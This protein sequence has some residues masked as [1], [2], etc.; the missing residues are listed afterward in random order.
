MEVEKTLLKIQSEIVMRNFAANC[1]VVHYHYCG[2]HLA[3]DLVVSC[4]VVHYHHCGH[5]LWMHLQTCH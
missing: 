2:Y 5:D 1:R 3:A 4:Q